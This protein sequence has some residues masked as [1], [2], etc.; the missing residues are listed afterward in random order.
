MASAKLSIFHLPR[1][2]A[3]RK[4]AA[5]AAAAVAE[6]INL[7]H[8]HNRTVSRH[9]NSPA[10]ESGVPSGA[11]SCLAGERTR[12]GAEDLRGDTGH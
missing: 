3:E 8:S 2:G 1:N 12:R 6:V 9:V 7:I 4:T 10:A 11:K 5:A